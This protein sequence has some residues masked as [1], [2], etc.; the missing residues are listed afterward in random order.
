MNINN[1]S[2]YSAPKYALMV[3]KHLLPLVDQSNTGNSSVFL[4]WEMT[5]FSQKGNNELAAIWGISN[6]QDQ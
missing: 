6:Q 1:Y 3:S 5:A 2:Y 4:F